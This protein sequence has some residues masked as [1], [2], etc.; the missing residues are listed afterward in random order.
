VSKADDFRRYALTLPGHKYKLGEEPWFVA[1]TQQTKDPMDGD[2][3]GIGWG[4]FR[5]ANVLRN[6]KPVPR[7]TADDYWRASYAIPGPTEVGDAAYFPR[8]G[9]KT[10][11]VWY[12]GRGQVIEAGNHGPGG[13]YP[14]SGYMGLCTVAQI[15][16]RNPVWGRLPGLDIGRLSEEDDLNEQETAALIDKRLAAYFGARLDTINDEAEVDA[17]RRH[18]EGLKLLDPG[19]KARHPSGHA[20]SVGFFLVLASRLAK[21][22]GK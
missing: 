13:R 7:L 16:A 19:S 1:G 4:L 18:L 2:C 6:G 8:T 20:M 5:K 3:S 21:L 9:R 15:N 14:G 17:A 11:V 22:V 10:H 12:I